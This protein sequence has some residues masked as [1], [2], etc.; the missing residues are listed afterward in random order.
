MAIF[1]PTFPYFWQTLY[2]LRQ[3][4]YQPSLLQDSVPVLHCSLCPHRA[5]CIL[6]VVSVSMWCSLYSQT[7][8]LPYCSFSSQ[9][10][11]LSKHKLHSVKYNNIKTKSSQ[12]Y[13][14]IPPATT[15]LLSCT[16]L[17]TGQYLQSST[18]PLKVHSR[19]FHPKPAS[20]T[21]IWL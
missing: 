10:N 9:R 18:R 19:T 5:P 7:K 17:H 11:I 6:Q 20:I 8:L 1:K 4:S 16:F 14:N 15:A 3:Q 21:N 2:I 13:L 12:A